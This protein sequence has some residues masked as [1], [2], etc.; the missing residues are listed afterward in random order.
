[1]SLPSAA[2]VIHCYRHPPSLLSSSA[3]V[4]VHRRNLPPWQPSPPL[5]VFAISCCPL[6]SFPFVVCR[7]ILHAVVVCHCRCPPLPSSS[8]VA[9]FHRCSHHHHSAVSA[10]SHRLLSSFPIAVRR[11][12]THVV[13]V[14]HRCHLPP[15]LFAVAIPTLALP[16]T[17][18]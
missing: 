14:R 8:T 9:I 12:V 5:R 10:V 11:P 18:C 3:T 1:M 13:V 6:L 2:F 4:D 17:R 7:L 16:P 15:S